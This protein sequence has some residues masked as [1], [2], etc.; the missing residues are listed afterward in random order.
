MTDTPNGNG[1]APEGVPG[2]QPEGGQPLPSLQVVAQY[3]RDLSFENP[4]APMSLNTSQGQAQPDVNVGIDVNAR[5]AGNGH[6]ECQLQ[7]HITA[8]RGDMTVFIVELAYGGLFR[9]ENVPD[10]SRQAIMLIEAPRIL[11]PYARRIIS[12]MTRDGGFMPLMLD[13]IDFAALYRHQMAQQG[14]QGQQQGGG[15]KAPDGDAPGVA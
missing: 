7:V 5:D 10:E 15:V 9:L 8:K 1:A 2:A 13:P 12:D 6:Y 11:F 4:N 14:Q 3:I